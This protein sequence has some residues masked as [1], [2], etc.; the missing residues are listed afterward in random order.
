MLHVFILM[1]PREKTI[2]IYNV[3][4]WITVHLVGGTLGYRD[5]DMGNYCTLRLF[6]IHLRGMGAG[7]PPESTG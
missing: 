3:K 1:H 7:R 2:C 6:F 5:L 4:L